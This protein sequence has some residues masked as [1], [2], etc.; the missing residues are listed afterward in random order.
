[1]VGGKAMVLGKVTHGTPRFGL[2]AWSPEQESAARGGADGGEQ[3]LDEGSL[4]RPVGA[5]Q[6]EGGTARDAQREPVHCADLAAPK[7][8]TIN[9]REA[10]SFYGV[11]TVHLTWEYAYSGP[12]CS[13]H[14]AEHGFGAARKGLRPQLI[15]RG[16]RW[17]SAEARAA[18]RKR[19]CASS[20]GRTRPPRAPVS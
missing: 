3:Q 12:N 16:F 6:A 15:V 20:T 8:R 17:T 10:V 9:F 18:R 11:V 2:P 19:R 4:P 7:G 1:L 5:E 14:P 13:M